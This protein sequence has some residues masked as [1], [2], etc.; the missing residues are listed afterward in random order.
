MDIENTKRAL[1]ECL[2]YKFKIDSLQQ[3]LLKAPDELKDKIKKEINTLTEKV[4]N[5][6]VKIDSL[7]GNNVIMVMR[8]RYLNGLSYKDIAKKLEL[9]YQWVNKI[10][11]EG[12]SQ[13]SKLL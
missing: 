6:R 11:N 12:I 2:I 5:V 1:D 4:M 7:D 9:S 13:M 8:L 3:E 10:H